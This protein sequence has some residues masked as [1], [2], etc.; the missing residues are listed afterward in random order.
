MTPLESPALVEKLVGYPFGREVP[1]EIRML[2]TVES[3][4]PFF[5]S[6]S[7]RM[8]VFGKVYPCWVNSFGAVAAI[9]PN[10]D[11]LGVKPDEFEVVAWHP[12]EG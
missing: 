5:V 8:A 4:I 11:V 2:T 3:D 7:R 1:L 9:L 6:S 10:G 12:K